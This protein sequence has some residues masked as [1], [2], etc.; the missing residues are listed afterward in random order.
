MG[1]IVGHNKFDSL[2]DRFERLV[3]KQ[4]GCWD[5]SG[6]FGNNGYARM[7]FNKM[8][9]QAHR[10]SYQIYKGPVGDLLVCHT[11]DN[12]KCTNPEHLFLGTPKDNMADCAKKM[13]HTYGSKIKHSVLKD[14]DIPMIKKLAKYFTHAEIAHEYRV[15]RAHIGLI[16]NNKRWPYADK[17]GE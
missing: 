3:V 14:S 9:I 5:W 1:R 15:S 11:C 16:I 7:Q 4:D 12:R 2:K 6:N 10:I 8:R 13:R 17:H